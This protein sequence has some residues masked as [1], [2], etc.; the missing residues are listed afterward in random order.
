MSSGALKISQMAKYGIIFNL[1]GSVMITS[2]AYLF[3]SLLI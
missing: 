2:F 1:V 3:W